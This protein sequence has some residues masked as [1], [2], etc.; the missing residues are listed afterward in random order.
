MSLKY[1]FDVVTRAEQTLAE[2]KNKAEKDQQERE[3]YVYSQ[4]PEVEAMRRRI[5]ERFHSLIMLVANH[6]KDAGAK[7]ERIRDEIREDQDRIRMMVADLTGDPDYLETKYACPECS[8]TGYVEGIRCKCMDELLRRFAI[9]ELNK[10]STIVLHTFDEFT[11]SC[12]D[13]PKL[14]T[15]MNNMKKFFSDYC[16][17]FPNNCKS[18][19]LTG[20]TGLGK[21]FFSTSIASALAGRGFAVAIGSV[22]DLLRD[23]END[24]FG[25]SDKNTM[26]LM[27]A[28]DMLIIDDLGTE[29]K[30]PFNDSTIYSI[31][32][33]RINQ[34]KA[35]II[36]TNMSVEQLNERYNEQIAS[37]IIGGFMPIVFTGCDLRQKGL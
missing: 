15:R 21:T 30:T 29:F 36:S 13:D 22:S 24:H 10:N 18:L 26:E 23:I 1:S 34:R 33:S 17:A 2:R 28:A 16:A 20:R 6:D 19:F 3:R 31:L 27:L 25:R 11:D 37:R 8:D 9:E 4:L 5:R 35:T 7:A 32:N 14:R 12:Y